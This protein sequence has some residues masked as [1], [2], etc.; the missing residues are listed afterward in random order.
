MSKDSAL[1]IDEAAGEWLAKRH[2]G[3]WTEHDQARLDAWLQASTRHRVAYLRL[4]R[5][6]DQA[7]RLKILAAGNRADEPPPPGR[8]NLSPFFSHAPRS[9]TRAYSALKHLGSTRA[10]LAVAALLLVL[11][12]AYWASSLFVHR[13]EYSTLVG[14]LQS[15]PIA[16]G[17]RVILNTDTAVRLAITDTERKIDLEHGEAYFEVA[18]DS[19]RPF[20]VKAG[21]KRVIAV[22]TKFS[23]RRDESDVQVVV[24]EGRVRIEAPNDTASNLLGPGTVAHTTGRA[25]LLQKKELAEVQDYLSWRSGFIVLHDISLAEAAAEF[26]RYN[27]RKI[28]IQDPAIA[29]LHIA[30]TFPAN[31]VDAFARLLERGFPLRADYTRNEITLV[32]R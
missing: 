26:N 1:R 27:T 9:E 15:V 2:C 6:W 7:A 12:G 19:R 24:I 18:P 4:E 17:S 13:N 23:V 29:S 28:V 31:N 25:T 22:G 32:A 11:F 14:G 5:G 10:G 21:N 20:I 8:W 3:N 30:G 16:D